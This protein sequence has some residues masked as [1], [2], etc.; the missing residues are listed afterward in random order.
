[1][2]LWTEVKESSIHGK[3]LFARKK[4]PANTLLGVCETK[5]AK[6]ENAYTLW[7][8]KKKKV[9]V[10][11]KFKYI[12]HSG[13]P[14]VAYYDDCSVIALRKIKK[15]EELTHDYGSQFIM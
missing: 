13:E 9:E 12:N 4:I 15:G 11:C 10:T 14:N 7:L 2:A 6:K 3:G 1:V 8:T 5:P